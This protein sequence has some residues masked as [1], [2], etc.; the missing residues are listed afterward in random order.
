MCVCVCVS[1]LGHANCARFPSKR[2]KDIHE[3]SRHVA[4]VLPQGRTIRFDM[5]F[6]K[7]H[8]RDLSIRRTSSSSEVR[9]SIGA[10]HHRLGTRL[11]HGA[12]VRTYAMGEDRGAAFHPVR[13]LFYV[14]CLCTA[15]FFLLLL[16][17]FPI[18]CDYSCPRSYQSAYVWCFARKQ[19]TS[20]DR[21]VGYGARSS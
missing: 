8:S 16:L 11:A 3:V 18:S 6:T 20:S 12:K 1:T 19:S 10:K 14:P 7:I 13:P 9:T 15:Y 4:Y 2:L 5:I 17:L 21:S